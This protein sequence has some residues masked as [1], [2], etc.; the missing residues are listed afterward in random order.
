MAKRGPFEN[1]FE[2]EYSTLL[3]MPGIMIRNKGRNFK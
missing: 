1:S 3:I 2:P